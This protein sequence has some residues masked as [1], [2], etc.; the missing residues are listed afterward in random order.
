MEFCL[1]KITL[2][3]LVW[4]NKSTFVTNFLN[5]F[6]IQHLT[7]TCFAGIEAMEEENSDNDDDESLDSQQN[8]SQQQDTNRKQV[9]LY[10]LIHS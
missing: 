10:G 5:W 1:Q 2:S 4:N 3:V 6:T 9:F 7:L 8:F